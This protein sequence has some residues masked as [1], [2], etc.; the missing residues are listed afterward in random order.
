MGAAEQ[1]QLA[2]L[3]HLFYLVGYGRI[4]GHSQ[5]DRLPEF[6]QRSRPVP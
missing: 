5:A 4:V 2:S 3:R 1:I 6:V